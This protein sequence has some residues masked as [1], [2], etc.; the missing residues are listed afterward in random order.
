VQVSG[1]KQP[2]QEVDELYEQRASII[3]LLT[4]ATLKLNKT[5]FNIFFIIAPYYKVNYS[6]KCADNTGCPQPGQE[7]APSQATVLEPFISDPLTKLYGHWHCP[8]PG[9]FAGVVTLLVVQ[10]FLLQP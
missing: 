10:Y 6:Q 1:P 3:P 9:A 7:L 5:I 8:L 4:N 2:V